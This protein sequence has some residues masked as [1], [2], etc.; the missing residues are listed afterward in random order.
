MYKASSG[1]FEKIEITYG[2]QKIKLINVFSTI[3]YVVVSVSS[4]DADAGREF[5]LKKEKKIV[6]VIL[7]KQ[8]INISLI[9]VCNQKCST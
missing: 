9:S 6:E 1:R 5:E 3:I 8:K 7:Q 2:R 4:K